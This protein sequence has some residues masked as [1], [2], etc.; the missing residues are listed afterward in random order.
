MVSISTDGV[1][2][3]E[4]I[5]FWTDLVSRH[6]TPV[7]IEPAGDRPLRGEVEVRMIGALAVA[8]VSGMGIHASHRRAHVARARGH[9]YAA[10]VHLD[11]EALIEHRGTSIPFKQG[12]V[13]ITDTRQEF[14]LGH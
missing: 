12:D 2:A 7:L 9:L 14:T 11:G 8:K 6:V 3:R 10:R 13:F 4:R 5:E 1:P